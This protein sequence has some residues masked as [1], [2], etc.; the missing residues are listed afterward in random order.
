MVKYMRL[1]IVDDSSLEIMLEVPSYHSSINSVELYLE[2]K[3][4]SHCSPLANHQTRKRS[5]QNDADESANVRNPRENNNNG[6]LEEDNSTDDVNCGNN[7]AAQKDSMKKKPDPTKELS[8]CVSKQYILSS[9]WLTE[10]E[11][12]VGMLFRDQEELKKAV[13]LYSERRQ[14][15]Y[16][17]YDYSSK[18][19]F[20]CT[21]ICGWDLK[22]AKTNGNGFEITEY[23][24]VHTCKPANVGSDFLAGEIEC[25]IKA[26]PSLSISELIKWVK[27][28]FSYTVSHDS[29]WEAKKKAITSILGDA[30]KCFSVFPKFMA[31]LCSSNKMVMD[32]QYDHFP[33][34]PKEASFRSVFWAFQQSI[35]GFPHCMPVI[36]VDTVDLCGKYGGKLLVATGVDTGSKSFPLTFAIITQKSLA[37]DSWR[38]FF[39][40]I[41]KKVTQR[42]GLCLITSPDPDIVA[43]HNEPQCQWAQHRFCISYLCLKF[44]D[45]FRN[46]L[47]T[48]FVHKSGTTRF[49]FKNAN[50]IFATY[51]FIYKVRDLPITTCILLIF[52]HVAERF[53]S[54]RESH[55]ES[56]KNRGDKF[57]KYVMKQLQDCNVASRTHDVLPLEPIG[58]RFQVAVAKQD[59][60]YSRYVVH[61]NDRICT[62]GILQ[63]VKYPCSH[64]LA[65]SR[66][67]NSDHLQYVNDCYSAENYLGTYAADFNPLPG[68]SDWSEASE[69]PRLFPPGSRAPSVAQPV[70]T[71]PPHN[72][73]AKASK[74]VT[75]RRRST[76]KKKA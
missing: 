7:E 15:D 20:R 28:E 76:S 10:R 45:V 42:E 9:S 64:V 72:K 54:R 31:A 30:D 68:V 69:V 66:R 46:N 39:E 25:L 17:V 74:L 16:D 51:G 63:L 70:P 11:L 50:T 59:G 41:R 33:N 61:L 44:Y 26:Q 60:G 53:K 23:K 32:W 47:M 57:A 1:P 36:M 18:I 55:D 22:A 65:V 52:D 73:S 13:K 2:V 40:C 4:V 29:M 71:A 12:Y 5:R 19:H 58:V 8:N 62:C 75:S 56:L 27:E 38:W 14:R 3:P 49:G 67:I 43:V 24:G 35:K 37:A 48:E 6:W 34:H 21:K